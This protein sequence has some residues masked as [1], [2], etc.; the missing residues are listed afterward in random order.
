M[1]EHTACNWDNRVR[2]NYKVLPKSLGALLEWHI[3]T[4][5]GPVCNEHILHMTYQHGSATYNGEMR[6][7]KF[8]S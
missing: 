2:A 4:V 5:P 6:I 3:Q 8:D 1:T 7:E